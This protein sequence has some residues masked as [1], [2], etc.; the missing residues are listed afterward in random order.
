MGLSLYVTILWTN[1]F[2]FIQDFKIILLIGFPKLINSFIKT[3]LE[4]ADLQFYF[5]Y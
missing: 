1:Y 5:I 4:I 3:I 2:D